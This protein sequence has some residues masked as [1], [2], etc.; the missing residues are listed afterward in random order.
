MNIIEGSSEI[1]LLRYYCDC[2]SPHTCVFPLFR[3]ILTHLMVIP[4]EDYYQNIDIK[5]SSCGDIIFHETHV[6]TINT[7]NE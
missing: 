7:C 4:D 5:I 2:I 6:Y 1:D 3:V